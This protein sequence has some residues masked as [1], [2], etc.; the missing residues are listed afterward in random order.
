MARW[1]WVGEM[2]SRLKCLNPSFPNLVVGAKISPPPPMWGRKDL[3][4]SKQGRA[5]KAKRG[6]IVIPSNNLPLK[7]CCKSNMKNVVNAKLMV[8]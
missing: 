6:K 5:S 4:R 7:I 3:G 1:E 8:G 2:Q